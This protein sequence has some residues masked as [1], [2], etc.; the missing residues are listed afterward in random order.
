MVKISVILLTA[1]LIGCCE[2]IVR[3]EI[4]E[5]MIPVKAQC[6]KPDPIT[7]PQLPVNSLTQEDK[8][9]HEKIAKQYAASIAVCMSYAEEQ[10]E[11]LNSYRKEIEDG[12]EKTKTGNN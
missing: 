8:N 4:V 10:E 1:F 11:V 5:V 7:K 9:N 12:S 2:P 3:T 6:P